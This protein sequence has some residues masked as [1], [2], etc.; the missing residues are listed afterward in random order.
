MS[1]AINLGPRRR[2]K[3]VGQS[4]LSSSFPNDISSVDQSPE[5][6]EDRFSSGADII[7][8]NGPVDR[9]LFDGI[10]QAALEAKDSKNRTVV[11]CLVTW[12]GLADSAYRIG[13]F[14]HS[15]YDDVVVFVPSYCKSAGTLIAC[16][17][18]SIVMSPFGELGPLDAQILKR[19]ELSERRSG[20]ITNYALEELERVSFNLFEHFMLKI[21]QRGGSISFKMASEIAANITSEMMKNVYQNINLDSIGEDARNL[22]IAAEYCERLSGKFRNIKRDSINKLV[23][24][25][26]SHDFVI[27][28]AEAK[29]LFERVELP[30]RTLDRIVGEYAQDM[31]VPRSSDTLVKLVEPRQ[32]Q[33]PI[34]MGNGKDASENESLKGQSSDVHKSSNGNGAPLSP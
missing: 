31:M 6:A 18:N 21:K 1:K 29:T 3:A 7:L 2:S 17:A 32:N 20:L 10:I 27:D 9:L 13:R 4:D 8:A 5:L 22:R 14:L 33:V 23:H 24:G 34:N 25:Y 30:T 26:V 11:L 16:S 19:D 28:T 12:G 15:F